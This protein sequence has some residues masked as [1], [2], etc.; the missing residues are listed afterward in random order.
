MSFLGKANFCTNGHSPTVVL[1][2]CH[3]EWHATCL[4]FSPPIYSCMLIF[5]FPPY[6]NC[7][8]WLICNKPSSF[9]I[10]TPWCDYCYWCHAHSLGFLFFRDLGYLYCLVLLGQALCVRLILPCRS[11]RPL[12]WCCIWW[13]SIYQ[14][15]WLPCIWVTA[16]LRLTC[17]I[18]VVQCLLFFPGWP[19]RYWIWPTSMVLLLF[20]HTFLP[21]SMWRQIICP[22]INCFQSGIFSL[23]WLWQLFAFGAFQRWTWWHLLI[24][25]NASIIT[26]WKHHYLGR[27]WG[28]MLSTIIGPFR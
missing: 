2:S 9:A 12:Q 3:S 17:V 27:P 11:S 14:V 1:I 24:L 21:T 6:V 22:G 18:K 5:P 13:H 26:P 4:Q 23:R 25:L 19:D 7:N 8:G 20:Q 15:R 16:L 28:W 10:S